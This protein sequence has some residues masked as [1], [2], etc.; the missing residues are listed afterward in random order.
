MDTVETA[1]AATVANEERQPVTLRLA[2]FLFK[3]RDHQ[4]VF[5][6]RSA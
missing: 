2:Q 3:P 6:P 1:A 4:E 5:G